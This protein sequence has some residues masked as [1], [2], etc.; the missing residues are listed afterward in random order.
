MARQIVTWAATGQ[1][2]RSTGATLPHGNHHGR[3]WGMALETRSGPDSGPTKA[4]SSAAGDH[5]ALGQRLPG[6]QRQRWAEVARQASGFSE[7]TRRASE[8]A[9]AIS[10]IQPQL[11]VWRQHQEQIART[12]RLMQGQRSLDMGFSDQTLDRATEFLE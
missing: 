10:A 7:A 8:A 12:I 1:Q 6:T 11:D 5:P 3:C 2:P 4:R 9:R